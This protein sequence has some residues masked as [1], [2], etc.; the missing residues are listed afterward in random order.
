MIST[1]TETAIVR[2]PSLILSKKETLSPYPTAMG[3]LPEVWPMAGTVDSDAGSDDDLLEALAGRLDEAELHFRQKRWRQGMQLAHHAVGTARKAM[4]ATAWS[5]AGRPMAV[6]HP[7]C[8]LIHEDPLTR[9]SFIKP[10]GYAGDAVM[11]DYIYGIDHPEHEIVGAT[12]LGSWLFNYTSNSVAARSVRRR[13]HLLAEYI[14]LVCAEQPGARILSIAC[15]HL[16]ELRFSH[17]VKCRQI[18]ELVAFDQDE[19]SLA[20]VRRDAAAR[21]VKCV[22][23]SVARLIVGRPAFAEFDLVY[24]AGL[25]D[26]LDQHAALRLAGTMFKM[27]RPGGRMLIP[28]FLSGIY[29]MGYLEA[30]AGWDL[31]YRDR[32][33]LEALA[34]GLV[35]RT[36]FIRYFEE[37]EHN[38]GF[39]A[40]RKASN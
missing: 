21:D 16:R 1:S 24:A 25:F 34:D 33:T 36:D 26:Y 35:G 5:S 4:S 3:V 31:I 27:L 19:L 15:G 2:S 13:M 28:N 10:R 30:F 8:A 20:E 29:D 7:V 39:L 32:P 22:Q 11:I 14:D 9:R 12:P 18:G 6:A 38:V 40:V 23:G 17:A 37:V